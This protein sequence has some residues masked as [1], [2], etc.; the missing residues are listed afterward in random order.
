MFCKYYNDLSLRDCIKGRT[1]R[2]DAAP[3]RRQ[4]IGMVILICFRSF[5]TT[6]STVWYM[7]WRNRG[8]LSSIALQKN[9]LASERW[10]AVA[11]Q[12]KKYK[13]EK[14]EEPK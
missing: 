4:D 7:N 14:F 2:L 1:D 8:Y 13:T 10:K 3:S 12:L 9:P 5:L 6:H 11:D